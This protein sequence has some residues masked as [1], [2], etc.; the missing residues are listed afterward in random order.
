[1]RIWYKKAGD[2]SSDGHSLLD[3]AGGSDAPFEDNHSW[4][5]DTNERF[6][7]VFEEVRHRS[8]HHDL[9]CAQWRGE[10]LGTAAVGWAGNIKLRTQASK[11]ALAVALTVE[12]SS[13][14]F[15]DDAFG[16]LCAQAARAA[17]ADG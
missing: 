10:L 14:P 7:R 16:R 12:K 3:R 4:T 13:V 17:A 1:M 15:A 11:L 2:L 5:C 8:D 9:P 6:N